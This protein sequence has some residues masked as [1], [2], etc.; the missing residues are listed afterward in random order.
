MEKKRIL[1]VEDEALAAKAVQMGLTRMGFQ[2][3]WIVSSGEEAVSVADQIRPHLVLMDILLEG[4][5]DGIEAGA[6][7]HARFNIPIIYLTSFTDE[8]FIERAKLTEPFGYLVKPFRSEELR[9]NIEMALFKHQMEQRLQQSEEKYRELVEHAHSIILK[10]DSQGRITFLNEFG[11]QLFGYAEEEV[12]G[13]HIVGTLIP[14]TESAGR[15]PADIIRDLIQNPD[16]YS[17]S[18]NE[19]I[20]KNGDRIWISWTHKA[21]LSEDGSVAEVLGIGSDITARKKAEAE[22]K[23]LN[24]YLEKKVSERT[25]ELVRTNQELIEERESLR[26]T[27]RA[28]RALSECTQALIQTPEELALFREI[29]R[30]LVEVG[31][32]RMAWV[33]YALDDEAKT[34]QPVAHAGFDAGY[35]E[36]A[37]ITWADEETGRGPTGTAI[38]TVKAQI[39]NNSLRNPYFNRW[40][41]EAMRRGYASCIA[42]PLMVNERVIGA[43]TV[44]ASEPDAFDQGELDLLTQLAGDASYGISTL[45]TR[46]ERERVQEALE[47]ARQQHE[48]ILTSTWEGIYGVD[49]DGNYT[50]VNPAAANMLRCEPQEL[51]G[52]RSHLICRPGTA[53]EGLCLEEESRIRSILLDGVPFHLTDEVFWRQDGSTFPVEL[54]MTP[55]V[56]KGNITGGVVTFWDITERKRAQEAV[57]RSEQFLNNIIEQSPFSMWISDSKGTM[58]R[59]N[60]ACRKTL[61]IRD[62]EVVGKYNILTDSIVDEQ[63]FMPLVQ[64]VFEHGTTARF[65]IEYDSSRLVPLELQET[66]SLILDVTIFPV[67]GP[68]GRPAN[69]V[70]QHIDVTERRRAETSLRESEERFRLAMEAAS[71]GIWDW[72]VPSGQTYYSPAYF[73]MLGYEPDHFH[74]HYESWLDLIHPQD[75]EK[76]LHANID[77]I[78]G[79]CDAFETEFRMLDR[80][81]AWRWI[82]GRGK[83]IA[84]D[85]NGRSVRVIGTHVDIS[86][87]KKAEEEVRESEHRFRALVEDVS[88]VSVQGYDESRKVVFWNSASESLYGYSRDEALGKQLEDLIIPPQMRGEVITAIN[89]WLTKGERIPAGE[90]GLMHKAGS[91]IPVYSNHVMLE[92]SRGEKEMFCVDLD[93]WELKKAEEERAALRDQLRQ[94]Q[95]MEAIGT[96]AG[97][98]AHDFNNLLTVVLGFS[99]LLLT[100]T[101]QQAPAYADLQ[102]INQAAQNGAD[103]VQGLLAFSR[104]SETKPRPINLNHQID[105][106]QK[107]LTRTI[108]K[109]IEI[110]LKLTDI[111]SRVN[112]DPTQMDQVLMNLAVNAKDAMPDGGKLTIETAKV[113]LDEEY[114]QTHLGAKPG[115]YVLL[116]VSDTGHGMDKETLDHIFEPF[117]TTKEAGKGTGLGLAMVYGIVTRH[118]GQIRCYSKPGQGTTFKIYL[119]TIVVEGTASE[120]PDRGAKP[121]DGTET[122]LLVDDE[123]FV[124]DLG[125][126]VLERSAYT[127]LTAANGKEALDLYKREREK[128]SLVILDL[129]MPEMGGKQCLEELLTIDPKVRVLIASGFAAN[130]QTKQAIETG[131][132]GFV[133]KPYNLKGM[134][135]AVRE[136]LDAD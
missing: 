45:R 119:P 125:R 26:R 80:T 52:R 89:N 28:L 73:G 91:I 97:G 76:T 110:E 38:R 3:D 42:L 62:D 116:S 33:G 17:S 133:G 40:R 65:E 51:I 58:I 56:E 113:F 30:V 20:G 126:R 85:E 12:L 34:V 78:E 39:N 82:L 14:E 75:R 71:D 60:D 131:A 23:A 24:E 43:L 72:N 61:R 6:V 121:R 104:K 132:R 35:L 69:V 92:N 36:A 88:S 18:E 95:K 46:L 101:N 120:N 127:V 15:D 8:G 47:R 48:L 55:T 21:V 128:I 2:A 114:A 105:Q 93:L 129:I 68:G 1:I 50:F 108:P 4:E 13:R 96:L 102:R 49:L 107:M 81:G 64:S 66:V 135:Q 9:T 98:I 118:G 109:M 44:Y 41:P 32:Y 111:L 7:I 99:E 22:I 90:L 117:Y 70:V 84:R 100:D 11:Q 63:G 16:K 123:E 134:L 136:V 67:L 83:S 122:I 19:S 31:G 27:T 29:C 77:C 106:L 10:V 5:M 115:D 59:L 103:L 25:A 87:L 54:A 86:R 94:A 74:T 57:N 130:G 53:D 37:G 124:R 112:A 79:R